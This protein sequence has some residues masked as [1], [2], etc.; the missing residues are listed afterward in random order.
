MNDS[1]LVRCTQ[2]EEMFPWIDA[3]DL[4]RHGAPY[5]VCQG[6]YPAFLADK[7]TLAWLYLEITSPEHEPHQFKIPFL[8]YRGTFIGALNHIANNG[9][10]SAMMDARIIIEEIKNANESDR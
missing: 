2:C 8:F 6:C 3:P 5:Y 7:H 9:Y 4:Q 10:P 1:T